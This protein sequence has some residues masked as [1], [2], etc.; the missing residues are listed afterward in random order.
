MGDM[1]TLCTGGSHDRRIGD[2]GSSGRPQTA[3]A[4]GEMEIIIAAG[5][6]SEHQRDRDQIPAFPSW[7]PW[8]KARTQLIRR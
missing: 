8:Q 6:C 5:R 3:P 7:V 1:L 4:M 2:R